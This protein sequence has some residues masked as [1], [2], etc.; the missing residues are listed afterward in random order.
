[1]EDEWIFSM[2]EMQYDQ[3][4]NE[5]FTIWYVDKFNQIFNKGGA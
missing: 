1:M 3:Y 5:M 2:Y 4:A